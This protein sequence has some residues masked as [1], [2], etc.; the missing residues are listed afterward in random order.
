[1]HIPASCLSALDVRLTLLITADLES[2]LRPMVIEVLQMAGFAVAHP[3]R[4]LG[5]RRA[6]R[7]AE[8]SVSCCVPGRTEAHSIKDLLALAL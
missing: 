1:M 4:E 3:Q 2:D 7:G 6:V 8:S 5:L